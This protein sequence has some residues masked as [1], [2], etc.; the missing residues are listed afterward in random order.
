MKK[1]QVPEGMLIAAIQATCD[2][3]LGMAEHNDLS[4]RVV[5]AALLWLSENPI[6]PTYDQTEECRRLHRYVTEP[7]KVYQQV[8][9]EWQRRMFL[10]PEE[11]I[12][13]EIEGM[14]WGGHPDS[15]QSLTSKFL[16]EQIITAY[17]RG[18]NSK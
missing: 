6:E 17:R 18:K 14:L 4:M 7:L 11:E 15:R 12:P 16:N 8:A 3:R 9:V 10:A 1:I 13:E 5:K 2:T